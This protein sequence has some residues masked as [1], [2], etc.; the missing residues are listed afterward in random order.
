MLDLVEQ[1]LEQS[2]NVLADVLAR[3]IAIATGTP[4]S[5]EGAAS[6]TRTVL[7][8]LAVPG[9][10]VE[11]LELVDG[12]GLSTLDRAAPAALG[13]LLRAAAD[14]AH[15]RLAPIIGGLP[16]AGWDGTLADRYPGANPAAGVVRAKTGTLTGVSSLGGVLIDA[17]GRE[18][19]FVVIADQVTAT[20]TELAEA[21]LDAVAGTLASCGCP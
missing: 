7:A 21:A 1:M 8:G 19:V 6:A 17:D 10:D 2:D 16:V 12:S 4:A 3:Q 9:L 18:L 13:A 20:G 14:G 15:P 11:S 5:F